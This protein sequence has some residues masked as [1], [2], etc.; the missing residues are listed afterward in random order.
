MT[1]SKVLVQIP[2]AK[3]LIKIYCFIEEVHKQTVNFITVPEPN[4]NAST[5]KGLDNCMSN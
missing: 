2:L 4:Y 3:G 1:N 5:Q